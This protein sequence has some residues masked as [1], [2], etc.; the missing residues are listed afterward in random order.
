M[1]G[2]QLRMVCVRINFRIWYIVCCEGAFRIKEEGYWR[3]VSQSR[4][5][6]KTAAKET[7]APAKAA[8]N[9]KFGLPSHDQERL[10]TERNA[11]EEALVSA[12]LCIHRSCVVNASICFSTPFV[13]TLKPPVSVPSDVAQTYTV[14]LFGD[15]WTGAA[16]FVSAKMLSWHQV[17]EGGGEAV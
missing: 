11:A 6:Q 16:P 10:A 17:L 8:R 5:A 13:E 14:I 15:Q 3:E 2:S 7:A 4:C 1:V 9:A 12:L